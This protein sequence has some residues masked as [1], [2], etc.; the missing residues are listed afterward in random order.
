MDTVSNQHPEV[1]PAE[2]GQ[3]QPFSVGHWLRAYRAR[4]FNL[5][6]LFAVIAFAV[7]FV[8]V[9]T[10]PYFAFDLSIARSIQSLRSAPLDVLMLFI[11]GLGFEPLSYILSGLVI[12]YLFVEG[13]RWEAGSALFAAL[14][15]SI[16]GLVI[17]LIVQRARPTPDLLN[18]FSPLND[19][20]FPSGHVLFF[21]AFLGF[22]WFLLYT[23]GKPSFPRTL[24]LVFFALLV[25]LVGVSRVYL[26]QHWPSDVLGAYLF[27]S[28]WLAL[29]L[30]LYRRYRTPSGETPLQSAPAPGEANPPSSNPVENKPL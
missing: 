14:G 29:T 23:H 10:T 24:G 11:S 27:G 13:W 2:P 21:T 7:L 1:K 26:G 19:Y 28:L 6:V 30:Y 5:Y 4:A 17:K 8:L 25:A 22:L 18:V 9:R 16:M 3:P 15:V 20:S 12:L